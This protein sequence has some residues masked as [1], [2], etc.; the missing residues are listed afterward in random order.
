MLGTPPPPHVW[1]AVQLP[2][3]MTLPQPS[4]CGPHRCPQVFGTQGVCVSDVTQFVRS[5]IWNSRILSCAE[6][7]PTAHSPLGNDLPLELPLL[8]TWKSLKST[9]PQVLARPAPTGVEKAYCS[10]N[11]L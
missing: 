3:C 5:K 2:H 8:Y 7:G 4:D 10:T 6:S 1:G 9:R 11:P